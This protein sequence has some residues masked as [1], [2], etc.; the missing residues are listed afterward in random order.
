VRTFAKA[1]QLSLKYHAN[2]EMRNGTVLD[3]GS[4]EREKQ[5][6]MAG[7]VKN[8]KAFNANDRQIQV[9]HFSLQKLRDTCLMH[10]PN[11][12]VLRINVLGVAAP[13]CAPSRRGTLVS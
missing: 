7:D 10:N 13:F 11:P 2:S 6:E 12:S 9:A 8:F 1:A 3:T 4:I 5:L